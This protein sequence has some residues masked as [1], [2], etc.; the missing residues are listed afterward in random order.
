MPPPFT[1]VL[2]RSRADRVGHIDTNNRNN[3]GRPSPTF[4]LDNTFAKKYA[5]RQHT[6]SQS[7]GPHQVRSMPCVQAVPCRAVSVLVLALVP[8]PVLVLVLVCRCWC[9]CWCRFLVLML[10]L[11]LGL[12]W[13]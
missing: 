2:L 12:C 6:K 10:V 13:C 9:W 4:V 11:A 8:V 3:R 1:A 7:Q 5:A